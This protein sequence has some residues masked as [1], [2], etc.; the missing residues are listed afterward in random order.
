MSQLNVTTLKHESAGV[1]N[2]VLDASGNATFGGVAKVGGLMN[3]SGSASAIAMDSAGRVTM[4]YQPCF[5]AYALAQV[6]Y[7]DVV[8]YNAA[9]VNRGGH[10]N[11]SSYRFTAPVAG[12]YLFTFSIGRADPVSG[13]NNDRGIRFRVNGTDIYAYNP[14]QNSSVGVY[15]NHSFTVIREL[16]AGDF[17][18][19]ATV[20][21]TGR[22]S[23]TGNFFCGHLLG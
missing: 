8:R 12:A 11:A 18:D 9:A 19:I 14:A 23:T 10:Y 21:G 22:Y 20:T 5:H 4:P 2:L 7:N 15:H 17:V 16:N 3:P 6:D 13:T 1:N